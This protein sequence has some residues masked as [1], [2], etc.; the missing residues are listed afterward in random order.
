MR[1]SYGESS[2]RTW[3]KNRDLDTENYKAQLKQ[4][5]VWESRVYQLEQLLRSVRKEAATEPQ[6]RPSKTTPP[7]SPQPPKP[8]LDHYISIAEQA[9]SKAEKLEREALEVSQW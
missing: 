4:A 9:Q 1:K 8:D 3:S 5:G 7:K 2:C 6:P